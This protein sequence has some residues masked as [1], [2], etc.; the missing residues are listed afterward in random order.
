MIVTTE[1]FDELVLTDL[2]S[3]TAVTG[4]LQGT[5]FGLITNTFTPT[6]TVTL[7]TIV[8]PTY[9]GYALQSATFT[10]PTRDGQGNI[11][12]ESQLLIWQEMTT[13]ADVTI[14]GWFL[15]N[16]GGTALYWLEFF[17]TPQ[18][19]TDLIS[20]LKFVVEFIQTNPNNSGQATLLP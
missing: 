14:T 4:A 15:Q 11:N 5:K 12:L 7:T 20:V 2:N 10:G 18:T 17:A 16:S 6:K 1:V 8:Q 13:P 19:L 9:T 3:S